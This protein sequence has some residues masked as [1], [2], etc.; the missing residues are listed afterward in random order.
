M[1][2]GSY[3]ITD[4]L[5]EGVPDAYVTSGTSAVPIGRAVAFLSSATQRI[6]G[7]REIPPVEMADLLVSLYGFSLASPHAEAKEIDVSMERK[8][9]HFL[10]RGT[11]ELEELLSDPVLKVPGYK[12]AILASGRHPS[13][14]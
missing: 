7:D 12:E 11:A 3:R 4:Y 14:A 6:V 2:P 8:L 9:F 5:I 1:E 13:P 10:G